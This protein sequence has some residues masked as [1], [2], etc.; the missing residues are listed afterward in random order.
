VITPGPDAVTA[1]VAACAIALG[2]ALACDLRA[3]RIPNA[4]PLA[5]ALA[6][7]AWHALPGGAGLAAPAGGLALGAL[8]LLAPF[9]LGGM[10]GGDVKLLAALGAWLGP[11]SIFAVF[12]FGAV[13]GAALA[14]AAIAARLAP[15]PSAR[16]VAAD[17]MLFA[18]TRAPLPLHA[19][20]GAL[21]YSLAIAA[22]FAA[23]LVLGDLR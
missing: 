7:L 9:A 11:A 23:W 8:L 19:G 5:A 2:A 20:R 18:A 12:A 21:P 6:A 22:G 13:A 4:I 16:R 1:P 10:G 3:R 17:A 15:V 14:L